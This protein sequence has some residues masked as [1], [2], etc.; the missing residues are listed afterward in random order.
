MDAAWSQV[1]QVLEAQRRVRFGQLGVRVSQVWY[2]RHVMPLLARDQQKGLMLIA[3]LQQRILANG[4]TVQQALRTSVV[5]PTM[6][7]TVL[8]RLIRPRGR[9]VRQLPFSAENRRSA[10]MARVNAREVS[11]APPPAAPAGAI[12]AEAAANTVT[13]GGGGGTPPFHGPIVDGGTVL[14]P[15]TPEPRAAPAYDAWSGDTRAASVTT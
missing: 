1:G 14:Q 13:G 3:P 10:L 6:T 8:R 15:I 5:Q 7:S 11:A 4:V 2:A 12:T 9:L